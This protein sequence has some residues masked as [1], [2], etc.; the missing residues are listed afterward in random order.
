MD[1]CLVRLSVCAVPNPCECV[2]P[3][4]SVVYEFGGNPPHRPRVTLIRLT[5]T[6]LSVLLISAKRNRLSSLHPDV[7]PHKHACKG[8]QRAKRRKRP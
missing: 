7:L 3:V 2:K 1:G 4:L 8:T 6:D 5:C